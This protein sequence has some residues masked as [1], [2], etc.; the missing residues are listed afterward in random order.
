MQEKTI[1]GLL[2]YNP[3]VIWNYLQKDID[4][5]WFQ[6]PI[7]YKDFEILNKADE[8]F[9]DNIRKNFGR[10]KAREKEVFNLPKG[11]FTIRYSLE[12]DFYDRFMYLNLVLPLM[13]IF[14][15][16][17][18]NRVYSHRYCGSNEYLFL[19]PI[20]QWEKFEGIVRSEARGK[21]ILETDI[22]NYF[23]N[24]RLETLKRDLENCL[25]SVNVSTS[26]LLRIRFIIDRLMECLEKWSYDGKRGLPQ[27]RD[28]SS[29]LAN[30]YLHSIDKTMI[31][32][33]FEYYRY[34]D[35][36]RI[37][38]VDKFEARRALKELVI[39]LRDK[40]LSLNGKK[41]RKIKPESQE[42]KD[43]LQ[44]NIDLKKID[45]LLQ[46]KK[47]TNVAI[48]YVLLK[49][50]CLKLIAEGKFEEREF[51]FCINRLSKLARCKD[52]NV[53]YGYWD[54][55]A[56][57]IVNAIV[58]CPTST[59]RVYDFLASVGLN[60]CSA[61]IIISYLC[62]P[63]KN[64]YEWQSYWLWKLLIV[65][66]I[67]DD[68]VCDRARL[69]IKSDAKIPDIAGA[70]LYLAEFGDKSDKLNIMQ[71][72]CKNDSIF[73]QRHKWLACKG[74]DWI[75]DDIQKK[76]DDM[77]KCLHGTYR[78]INNNI[79]MIVSPP[80]PTS[81]SDILRSVHQYD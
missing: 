29:F 53:P 21:Y 2:K 71:S 39:L 23:E 14:D 30:I 78:V 15:P 59:D 34:M 63:N 45:S 77:H 7:R 5:D 60:T 25:Q 3:K 58:D 40:H 16:L 9:E 18:S 27:N 80:P 17:L 22:Q 11:N 48:G 13:K 41:T 66:K 55:I 8:F 46:T 33:S 81:L 67:K 32:N 50:R 70:I 42:H 52:Y 51:R 12:T 47:K 19:Y 36:I 35:D 54:E 76:K 31:E 57:G 61:S 64:I 24:I 79:K 37:I 74:L 62:D 44:P 1:F 28:C 56:K 72:I 75:S 38:C 69:L 6:D 43:I 4:D 10:Y 65:C 26:E 20:Y 49:D 68:K 73:L